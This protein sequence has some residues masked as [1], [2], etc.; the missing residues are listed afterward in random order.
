MGLSPKRKK[1]LVKTIYKLKVSLPVKKILVDIAEEVEGYWA[2]TVKALRMEIRVLKKQ[3]KALE[4]K[5]QKSSE[6]Y[7]ESVQE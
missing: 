7:Y 1:A 6:D 5:V 2:E 3:N 4:G